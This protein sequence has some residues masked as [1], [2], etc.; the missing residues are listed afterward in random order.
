VLVP[1]LV[2]RIRDLRGHGHTVCLVEHRVDI[3]RDLSDRVIVMDA[4]RVALEGPA[5]EVLESKLLEEIYLGPSDRKPAQQ[6][7]V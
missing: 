5:D 6:E 7:V 2:A 3:V 4:G 1:E